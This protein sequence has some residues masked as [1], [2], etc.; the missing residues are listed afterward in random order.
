MFLDVT[1]NIR[2]TYDVGSDL[3]AGDGVH[4]N[5]GGGCGG[6]WRLRGGLHGDTEID[7]KVNG[8]SR[9]G[10]ACGFDALGLE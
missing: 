9:R 4:L 10:E 7:G 8:L 3:S 6:R 5:H 2:A 1:G